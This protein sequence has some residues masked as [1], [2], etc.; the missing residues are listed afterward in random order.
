MGIGTLEVHPIDLLGAYGAIANG[1][2]L[3]PRTTILKVTDAERHRSSARPG[4]RGSRSRATVISPQA[5]YIIT[6]ILA[7]NTNPK[8]NPFWGEWAVYDGGDPPAGR[9][10]D[11]HDERQPRRPRLRLPRAAEG[12]EGARPSS[13]GVWMGNSD[14]AP[15]HRHA[16]ARRRRRRSGRGS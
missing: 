9:L 4:D 6:D 12:P 1:G 15:E 2:V 3:M 7:G 16:V 5:A 8:V 11:R 13:V 14:N 10:Q